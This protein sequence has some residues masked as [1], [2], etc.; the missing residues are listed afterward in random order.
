MASDRTTKILLALAFAMAAPPALADDVGDFYKSKPFTIVVGHAVGTGFDTYSRVLA[1][2]IGR[3]IPGNPNVVVQNMVGASGIIPA[4]WLY[5]VAP[6]DGSVM[7][8]FVHTVA[9][10][11]ILGN[12]A[13]RFDA[14]KL[15]WIG[16]MDE[17]IGICGVSKDSGIAKF[18]D[19]LVKETV[20][21]GTGV[22]GP[23]SKNALAVK[24]LLG[25][26]IKVVSGYAGSASVK[27]AINR[28]EVQGICGL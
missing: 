20:F 8:T 27:L 16:N 12:N 22:S 24:H 23:L 9:L 26:K 3:H 15:T 4:N 18:E 6:R 28:G 14:S 25:A 10:E 11:P 21:G 13:A 5:S 1:R 7:M 2:H 17:G 19:L